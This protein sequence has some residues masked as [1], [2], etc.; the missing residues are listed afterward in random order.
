MDTTVFSQRYDILTTQINWLVWRQ[1][2][3]ESSSHDD[4][5]EMEAMSTISLVRRELSKYKR[6]RRNLLEYLG[7][8]EKKK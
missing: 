5:M 3:L 8:K 6:L 1:M 4:R 2:D 7:Q